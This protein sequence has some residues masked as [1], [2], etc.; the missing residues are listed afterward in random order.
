MYPPMKSVLRSILPSLCVP[1]RRRRMICLPPHVLI[2]DR[3]QQFF[4]TLVGADKKEVSTPLSFQTFL[5]FS[6]LGRLSNLILSC[7]DQQLKIISSLF[8][9]TCLVLSCPVLTPSFL[10]HLCLVLSCLSILTSTHPLHHF[11]AT[12]Y[13]FGRGSHRRLLAKTE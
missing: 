10:V 1:P 5:V 12:P 7:L 8:W 9:V 4:G 3:W 13:S 11:S 6:F 2:H